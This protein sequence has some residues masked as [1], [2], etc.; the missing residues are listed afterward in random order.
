LYRMAWFSTRSAE[1]RN[2]LLHTR[3]FRVS[4]SPNRAGTPDA[5]HEG[6]RTAP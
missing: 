3:N 5:I 2:I 1:P 6:E 4:V